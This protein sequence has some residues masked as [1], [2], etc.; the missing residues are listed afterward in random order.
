MA[1]SRVTSAVQMAPVALLAVLQVWAV[2]DILSV[3]DRRWAVGVGLVWLA[4]VLFFMMSA[5]LHWRQARWA[6]LIC[7]GSAYVGVHAFVLGVPLLS[8]LAFL[9]LV[10]AQVELRILAD[11]F[12]PL[13]KATISPAERR[14][15]AG[16]LMRAVVRLAIALVLAI[17]VPLLAADLSAIGAVPLTTIPSALLLATALVAVI[18]L[19]ALLPALEQRASESRGRMRG[20]KG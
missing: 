14:R 12:G 5:G 17:A 13:F 11:R 10:I 6:G 16:A 20:G 15:I 4:N 3:D 7:L 2:R 8:A 19:L 9:V 18:V 1:A